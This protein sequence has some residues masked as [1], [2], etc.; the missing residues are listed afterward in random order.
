MNS[1]IQIFLEFEDNTIYKPSKITYKLLQKC[2]E[3]GNEIILP[4]NMQDDNKSIPVFIFSQ[5]TKINIQGNFY[6]VKVT[7]DGNNIEQVKEILKI[8]FNLFQEEDNNFVGIACTFQEIID[9]NKIKE[10][11][12]KHFINFNTIEEDKIHFSMIREIDVLGK[13]TRCLEGYSTTDDEFILH[14]EFNM[15]RRDFKIMNFDDI[16]SFIDQAYKY[17]EEKKQCL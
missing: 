16:I 2:P 11:K 8:I 7:I 17:K 12:N 1:F 9:N 14:F 4:I 15:K 6:N 5:N 13:K 3:L 10:F